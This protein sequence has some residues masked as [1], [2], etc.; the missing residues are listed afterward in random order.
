MAGVRMRKMGMIVLAITGLLLQYG[1]SQF[2]N[3]VCS[4]SGT[5]TG[6]RTDTEFFG[7][8]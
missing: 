6:W 5:A 3:G 8:S 2:L 7:W 4:A 1:L